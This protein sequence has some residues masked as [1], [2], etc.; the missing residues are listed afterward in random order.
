MEADVKT[1]KKLARIQELLRAEQV[2]DYYEALENRYKIE[3]EAWRQSLED[4]IKAGKRDYSSKAPRPSPEEIEGPKEVFYLPSPLD[5]WIKEALMKAS[6]PLVFAS[7]V[8]K[9]CAVFNDDEED[10]E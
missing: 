1:L 8:A 7:A 10:E 5:A 6:F 4:A 3:I 9:T 2:Q